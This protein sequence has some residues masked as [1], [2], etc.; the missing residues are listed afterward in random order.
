[1]SRAQNRLFAFLALVLVALASS[2]L[3]GCA[4][5]GKGVPGNLL[6]E[7]RPA[8][9][10]GVRHVES[11][12]DGFA[13][14]EGDPWKSE[15][16]AI[17]AST[18]A[19]VVYDL[20]QS[21][22][23]RAAW[24]QGDNNDDYELQV[25]EDGHFYQRIW[26]AARTAETGLRERASGRIEAQ[27]RYLRLKPANGD[28]NWAV[29]ELVVFSELPAVFPP[30]VTRRTSH[31]LETRLRNQTLLF[32]LAL[33]GFVVLAQRG[34]PALWLGVLALLPAFAGFQFMRA[35]LDA[36]PP[37]SRE[38]SLVRGVVAAVGAGI[39]LW[40]AFAPPRLQ[41][42]RAAVFGVL[43][44]CGVGAVMAFYNLGHPQFYDNK[45]GTWTP[46]HHLDLR[47]YHATAKYFREIGYFRLYDADV[48]AYAEDSG[49]SLESLAA[50]NIRN[51][52]TNEVMTVGDR[53]EAIRVVKQRFSPE[54]WAAYK[55]DARHFRET[56]GTSHWL[57]TMLDLGG[58][59]TPVWM[60]IAHFLFT[61]FEASNRSFL[62]T[63]LFDPLLFLVMF[64]A[65]G[66]CFGLRAMLVSMIVFGANDFI[67]FGT[68]W[69]G[70]TLRHDWLAFLALGACA[71]RRERWA[72]GGALF[73]LA[74][75][76]RAFPTLALIGCAL[77]AAWWVA[78]HVWRERKLPG[79]KETLEAHRHLVRVALGALATVVVCFLL[80]SLVLSFAAWPAWYAKV[81]LLD[82]DAHVNPVSLHNV[83]AGSDVDRGWIFRTRM[84]LFIVMAAVFVG[85]T[86]VAARGKRLEQAAMLGLVFLPI[87]LNPANY[88]LH[89]VCLLPLVVNLQRGAGANVDRFDA[90]VW[91]SLLAMCAVQYFTV[92]IED[93]RL[94]FYLA[95]VVLIAA[96]TSMLFAIVRRDAAALVTAFAARANALAAPAAS[97]DSSPPESPVVDPDSGGRHDPVSEPP[98]EPAELGA[99]SSSRGS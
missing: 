43:G 36:W 60:A 83:I 1:M 16:V 76:I 17:L 74:A 45:L 22:P 51:L 29:S 96:L 80:S 34:L 26:L 44:V 86:L 81:S 6:F 87:L 4:A 71:L 39:V 3:V 32:G 41:P 28:G 33:A 55:R 92:M 35:L 79:L 98:A 49:I 77:P 46:V 15:L 85:L 7:R 5:R 70:S 2:S 38:V 61:G 40:E 25:S 42:R 31:P 50:T 8:Q 56:M 52:D 18:Q 68:N 93:T 82:V 72:L 54:R 27:G 89:I 47:Q 19:Y 9:S 58:N 67:M 11:L 63:G 14:R 73:G 48:A 30:H 20:G 21:L 97:R 84:P 75:A 66:R 65:I 91:F 62:I 64:V 69:G 78:E 95:S 88:Y 13:A 53:L 57:E 10:Q 23:I 59:A 12:T 99:Q 37:G 24:L 90:C 94:H